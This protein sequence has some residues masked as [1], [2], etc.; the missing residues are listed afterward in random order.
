MVLVEKYEHLEIQVRQ[1][2][3]KKSQPV[4]WRKRFTVS[5]GMQIMKP[6]TF[7]FPTAIMT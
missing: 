1:F 7:S 2:H 4:P 5:S 6:Y 3:G